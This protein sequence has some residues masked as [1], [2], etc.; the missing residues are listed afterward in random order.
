MLFIEFL[1]NTY[2]LKKTTNIPTLL[3]LGPLLLGLF[4][5][6]IR[7]YGLPIHDFSNAYIGAVFLKE[8]W[9]STEVYD[10][11]KF[12]S[13]ALEKGF[14]NLFLAYYPN[15]PFLAF[16]FYPAT[17]LSPIWAKICFNLLSSSLF[18]LMLV[19]AQRR[20]RF[21]AG[22]F[23]L[24]PVVFF[25]SL[26]NGL[27]FGQV[28]LLLS[29]LLAEGLHAFQKKRFVVGAFCWAI[30][31][32]LKVFPVLLGVLLI[33]EKHYKA[34]LV[35]GIA[36]ISL[37]SVSLFQVDMA[38]WMYYFTD[39]FPKS[40]SGTYYD[41][42][43]PAAKS[44][45]ML[46]KHLFVYDALHNP[47][48][49]FNSYTV[50]IFM[51]AFYKTIILSTAIFF[52][53]KSKQDLITKV[54]LWLIAG[55]LLSPG[56][57]S[58]AGILLLFPWLVVFRNDLQ[59]TQKQQILFSVL[60]ALYVNLPITYFYELP[61][62]LKFPKVYVLLLIF[63]Y[64]QQ[65]L[66]PK[67]SKRI[68]HISQVG[69]GVGLFLFFTV[70]AV[71]KKTPPQNTYVLE[72]EKHILTSDYTIKNG[73]LE[74]E[75]WTVPAPKRVTTNITVHQ[76][77]TNV[78]RIKDKQ[79]YYKGMPLTNTNSNKRKPMVING[80]EI[81]YLSDQNRGMGFYTLMKVRLTEKK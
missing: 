28:Y 80:K 44:A 74:Y 64:Y 15:T 2:Q 29:F 75:Y 67:E 27:Y 40:S 14:S 63:I 47:T 3:F 13:M 41:G 61:L 10:A 26:R 7:T 46:F 39:V 66:L 79:I 65:L 51:Q 8:G 37:L 9:W 48:P 76:F 58:Y 50:F 19:R 16:F 38:S 81:F 35:Y 4:Y 17:F 78:V 6:L 43:T 32:M 49:V 55:M 18:L 69:I 54:G 60:I 5:W 20:W 24:V 42:F 56:L 1:T 21:S 34:A 30:A 22:V 45:T 73:Q 36:C 25:T 11:W 57:S 52:T 62:Y 77:D 53:W 72:R 59:L 33:A 31:L 71:I 70:P 12:N 68:N 23:L